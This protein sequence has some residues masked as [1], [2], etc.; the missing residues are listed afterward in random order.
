MNNYRLVSAVQVDAEGFPLRLPIPSMENTG[1]FLVPT[2]NGTTYNY[3]PI[4]ILVAGLEAYKLG[5]EITNL[6]QFFDKHRRMY[7]MLLVH[8]TVLNTQTGQLLYRSVA[9]YKYYI[10]LDNK[11][12]LLKALRRN[13]PL[14][15]KWE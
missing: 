3:S 15:F 2:P 14:T 11:E 4:D 8:L 1:G 12:D 13:A 7:T 6:P 5:E 9:D 10:K